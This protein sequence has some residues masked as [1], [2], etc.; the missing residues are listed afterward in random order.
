[1]VVTLEK[2][3]RID[4]VQLLVDAIKMLRFVADVSPNVSD[5]QDHIA[6]VRARGDIEGKLFNALRDK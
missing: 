5:I 1:M 6:Y 3:I 2:D 4:D